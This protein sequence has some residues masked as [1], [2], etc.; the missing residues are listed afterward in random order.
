V[1]LT[2]WDTL[3]GADDPL[4]SQVTMDATEAVGAAL[5]LLVSVPDRGACHDAPLVYVGVSPAKNWPYYQLVP[6]LTLPKVRYIATVHAGGFGSVEMIQRL[7]DYVLF[8]EPKPGV[9]FA[10]VDH[11]FVFGQAAAEQDANGQSTFGLEGVKDATGKR[12]SRRR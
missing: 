4:M 2:P 3:S 1:T 5:E 12:N 11:E 9:A 8:I 6:S 10:H 7:I